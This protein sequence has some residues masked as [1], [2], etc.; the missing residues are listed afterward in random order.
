MFAVCILG[1]PIPKWIDPGAKKITPDPPG[2][3]SPFL[4]R[5][6]EMLRNLA[7]YVA[8]RSQ[9]P[10]NRM[11]DAYRSGSRRDISTC[12]LA[13]TVF[14]ERSSGPY[15][16]GRWLCELR[17]AGGA[18]D[19]R[20]ARVLEEGSRQD[21]VCGANVDQGDDCQKALPIWVADFHARFGLCLLRRD[22]S[23]VSR[24]HAE[25][26]LDRRDRAARIGRVRSN[27]DQRVDASSLM[28]A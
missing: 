27:A 6:W 25:S 18:L 24:N 8:N 11:A 9:N 22:D 7:A 19:M 1:L 20:C 13:S 12:E 28:Y 4:V 14:F 15:H 3:T 5:F 23:V 17:G 16:G 10:V 21:G 2:R 26:P